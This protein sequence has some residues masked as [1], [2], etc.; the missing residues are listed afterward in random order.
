MYIVCDHS[1]LKWKGSILDYLL[2]NFRCDGG[3]RETTVM[4]ESVDGVV[5]H[6]STRPALLISSTSWTGTLNYSLSNLRNKHTSCKMVSL[7]GFDCNLYLF[8]LAEDEDFSVLLEA[9]DCK[10]TWLLVK[11]KFS[12]FQ[13]L[14]T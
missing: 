11:G 10:L 2:Y 8:F 12:P 5:S 6:K 9:L 3:S 13:E 1:G 14:G 4:T 7:Y